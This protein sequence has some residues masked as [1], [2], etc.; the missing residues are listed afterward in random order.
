MLC[1]TVARY[2][3][4]ANSHSYQLGKWQTTCTDT[5]KLLHEPKGL[6]HMGFH[7]QSYTPD[8][9]EYNEDMVFAQTLFELVMNLVSVEIN[10]DR[11]YNVR[12]AF[13]LRVTMYEYGDMLRVN[14]YAH[15]I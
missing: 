2:P 3:L 11:E 1:A 12:S 10:D 8:D 5:I 7:M 6:A 4:P 9:A 13:K 14:G 15:L